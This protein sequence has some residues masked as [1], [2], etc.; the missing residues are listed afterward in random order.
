MK[1]IEINIELMRGDGKNAIVLFA[2]GKHDDRAVTF[3]LKADRELTSDILARKRNIL[4]GGADAE[5][6]AVYDEEGDVTEVTV[7]LLPADT[8]DLAKRFYEYD[9]TSVDAGDAD[10]VLHPCIGR[11]RLQ[12][13]VNSPY[14][15][16]ALPEDA[17]RY[18]VFNAS[19]FDD[20]DLIIK[21]TVLGEEVFTGVGAAEVSL[22]LGVQDAI[23]VSVASVTDLL[24][25]GDVDLNNYNVDFNNMRFAFDLG[26]Y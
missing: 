3:T 8:A 26:G 17:V 11:V 4:A 10:D 20:D 2:D 12:A 18:V 22:L 21:K 25:E 7:Y 5:L 6:T 14:S 1:V 19:D 13:D 23:D 15:G 16:S 9:V 24:F